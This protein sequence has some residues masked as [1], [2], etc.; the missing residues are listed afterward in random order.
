MPRPRLHRKAAALVLAGALLAPWLS[1]S[2]NRTPARRGRSSAVAQAPWQVLGRL[3]GAL[4]SV[5]GENGCSLD[6]DGRCV[7]QQGTGGGSGSGLTADN[8]CS[9]DPDGCAK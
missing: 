4:V 5:W 1:A 7:S 8:G 9:L 3:W 2:E 6:P